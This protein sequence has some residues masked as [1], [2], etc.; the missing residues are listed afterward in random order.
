MTE[1]GAT[2]WWNTLHGRIALA[3]GLALAV[4]LALGASGV[5]TPDAPALK[6]ADFVGDLFLRLLKMAIVPL[7]FATVASGVASINPTR[8]GSLGARTLVYFVGTTAMAVTMPAAA[9][10][11]PSLRPAKAPPR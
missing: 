8:L 3:F 11:Q 1:P 5:N 6:V 10:S 2:R 4:G 7:V 9:M